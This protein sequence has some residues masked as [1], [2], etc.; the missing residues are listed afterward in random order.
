MFTMPRDA[1]EC[2]Q[3]RDGLSGQRHHMHLPLFHAFGRYPP[4]CRFEIEFCP[5]RFDRLAGSAQG[6][7]HKTEG[8]DGF[9]ATAVPLY[10]A[11]DLA[12]FVLLE[13]S[14]MLGFIDRERL[15]HRIHRVRIST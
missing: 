11:K 2:A 14:L 4:D 10:I 6:Q 9:V 13:R 12:D 15:P 3:H 7:P 1:V 8:S 5:F